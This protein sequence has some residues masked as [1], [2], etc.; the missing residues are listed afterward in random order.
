MTA[1]SVGTL[2][3]ASIGGTAYEYKSFGLGKHDTVLDTNGIRG[4]R[5][6]QYA[7][8]RQGPYTVSGPIVLEPSK[9]CADAM[10]SY[11]LGG[12]TLQETL[13]TFTVAID[14]I[15]KLHTYSTCVVDK[16]TFKASQG[17]FLE[18]TLDIEGETESLGSGG[19][20]VGSVEDGSPL[21]FTDATLQ[22]ASTSYIFRECTVVVDNHVKKDRFMNSLTRTAL[23]ALDR[24][25]TVTLSLPYTADTIALYDTGA[26]GAT[27]VL[28]FTDA[29]GSVTITAYEVQ[30]PAQPPVTPG[31]DEVM[32]TL[33]GTAHGTGSNN[34]ELT[35]A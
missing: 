6:H 13:P 35:I 16:A 3:S 29:D 4:S 20:G 5:T 25:V 26:T 34:T 23:P 12:S 21:V 8:T 33:S 32:L 18:L 28:A 11:I 10:I 27:V 7:R 19:G 22:I 24:T 2:T 14:R 30:F 9:A 17:G 1:P 15:A 31:K